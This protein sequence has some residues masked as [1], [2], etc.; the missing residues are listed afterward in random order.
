[1][2]S[3]LAKRAGARLYFPSLAEK[4]GE[5]EDVLR[6]EPSEPVCIFDAPQKGSSRKRGLSH[7][8]V[9]IV[10]GSFTFAMNGP[11]PPRM[12]KGECNVSIFDYEEVPGKSCKLTEIDAM[13]FDME[14]VDAHTAFHPT[15]H[16][17]RGRSNTLSDGM[18]KSLVQK[19]ARIDQEAIE[20]WRE[21]SLGTPY[22]RIPTP[23]MD[24]LSALA[25]VAADFFCN[26]GDRDPKAKTLFQALLR[27]LV[28]QDNAAR[29]GMSA[30]AL[31]LRA[32]RDGHT[33]SALWYAE[34]V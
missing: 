5:G 33:S 19:A 12:T 27:L 14:D 23:Q 34:C 29:E 7:R 13:H 6:L 21:G 20:V 31:R 18:I 4:Q 15:F 28:H 3:I 2:L 16:V 10:G 17:Q 30:E 26:G 24:M 22:I 9:I 1:M 25:V 8:Q 11:A 32:N